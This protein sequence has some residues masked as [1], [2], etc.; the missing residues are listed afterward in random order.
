MCLVSFQHRNL[1]GLGIV[2][3]DL[4]DL[5]PGDGFLVSAQSS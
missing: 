2:P 3:G 5:L 4:S 1:E